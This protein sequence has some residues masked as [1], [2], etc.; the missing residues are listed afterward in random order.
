MSS[1]EEVKA[2]LS[3]AGAILRWELANMWGHVS[4]KTPDGKGFSLM[5]LREPVDPKIPEDDLLEYDLEGNFLSGRR[6]AIDE[7]FF[8][9]CPYRSREEVGA[10]IHCHPEM[11]LALAAVGQKIQPIHTSSVRFE[12]GVPVTSFLYGYWQEHG[13]QASRA[14][15]DRCAL[16]IQGHGTIVTGRTI[17]EACI[18]MVQLERTAKMILMGGAFGQAEPLSAAAIEE[19]KSIAGRRARGKADPVIASFIEW[20]YY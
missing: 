20:N 10:V 13:E 11:T 3:T 5:P 12:K 2:K 1:T 4:V 19:F 14:M 7:I 8:Y 17:E 16:I 6:D 18:N 15:G 9:S